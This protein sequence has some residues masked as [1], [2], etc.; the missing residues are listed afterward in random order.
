[1]E[2][3]FLGKRWVYDA[4]GDPVYASGLAAYILTGRPQADQSLGLDGRLEAIP[5]S[6]HLQSTGTPGT[7]IPSI[8]SVVPDSVDGVTTIH[9]DE[10]DLSVSRILNLIS[11]PFGQR[12][13]TAAWAE[14]TIQVQL[15]SVV[16]V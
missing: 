13:L 11:E 8:C 4:A 7:S 6:V 2:H 9:A 15:A 10:L 3:S 1:M 16:R 14:Q 12:L 5:E